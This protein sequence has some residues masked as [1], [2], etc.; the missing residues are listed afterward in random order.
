MAVDINFLNGNNVP[1]IN[2]NFQRVKQALIETL[3]REGDTPNQMNADLDM[4]SNDLLNVNSLNVEVL[5]INDVPVVPGDLG[6]F[7]PNSVGTINLIDGSV[8][9]PKLANNSVSTNKLVDESVTGVKIADSFTL[10]LPVIVDSIASLKG[11]DNTRHTTAYVTDNQQ[12]GMFKWISGDQQSKVVERT[13]TSTAFNDGADTFTLVGH[14]LHSMEPVTPSVNINGLTVNTVYYLIR[15]DADTFKL[16]SSMAN[17]RSNVALALTITG[18]VTLHRL[19]DPIQGIYTIPTGLP[20][21]GT[22]GIWERQADEYDVRMM[23]AVGDNVTN[24]VEAFQH[25]SNFGGYWYIEAKLYSIG[26]GVAY[27]KNGYGLLGRGLYKS[28]INYTP[29]SGQAF[30]NPWFGTTT[31]VEGIAWK[32]MQITAANMTTAGSII[33]LKNV[34]RWILE[35]VYFFG[36]QT[37]GMMLVDARGN[38]PLGTYYGSAVSCLF[39]LGAFG[40]YASDGFNNNR[41]EDCRFQ[42]AAPGGAQGITIIPTVAGFSSVTRISHCAFELPGNTMTGIYLDNTNGVTIEDCRFES[43]LTGVTVLGTNKHVAITNP[44]FESCTNKILNTSSQLLPV[45]RASGT[46][47]GVGGVV[48]TGQAYGCTITRGGVGTYTVNFT[49]AFINSG[50]QLNVMIAGQFTSNIAAGGQ[51]NTFITFEVRNAGVLADAGNINFT[52]IGAVA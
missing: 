47:N 25:A 42:Q 36:A 21:I 27:Y 3:G 15:V 23:G 46:F 9:E 30:Y 35:R 12:Y 41:I 1:N 22:S 17:A 28:V 48:V 13:F 20:I 45:I 8:T 40:I 18:N 33:A 37:T 29:T 26:S 5:Y 10:T 38:W 51:T 11:V 7:P 44:Y 32:D 31:M 52:V 4:N 39:G 14:N 43:L 16:A 49:D 6:S 2:T 24:D 34:Q 50:Y 19:R